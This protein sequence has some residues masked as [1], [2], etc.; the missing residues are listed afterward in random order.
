MR[1][2][3]TLNKYG[4]VPMSSDD[5]HGDV[6]HIS[7]SRALKEQIENLAQATGRDQSQIAQDA[8]SAY[9]T[10]EA[11]QL[12]KIHRGIADADAGRFVT[13]EEMEASFNRYQAY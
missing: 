7:I 6:L 3:R 8:V 1:K 13:D 12:A 10:F 11:E 4:E 9:V 5:T 2:K